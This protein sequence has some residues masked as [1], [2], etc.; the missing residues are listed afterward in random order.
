MKLIIKGEVDLPV[1]GEA[2]LKTLKA[3][4]YDPDRFVINGATLYF[5]F[6]DRETGDRVTL[7]SNGHPVEEVFFQ[8]PIEK[9]RKRQADR[10]RAK[11]SKR[12]KVGA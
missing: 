4:S 7:K 11:K 10:A 12:L 8:T 9:E 3:V 5:N 6:Y 1:L 2:M